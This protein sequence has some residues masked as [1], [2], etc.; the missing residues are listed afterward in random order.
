MDPATSKNQLPSVHRS[1][2]ANLLRRG[3]GIIL[4]LMPPRM[5]FTIIYRRRIWRDSESRSGSGSSLRATAAIR[6]ELPRLL[7][8]LQIKSMLDV[9]C[10][11]LNWMKEVN[12][13]AVNYLGVDIVADLIATNRA[14]FAASNRRFECLD[15]L[16]D[17]I[18]AVDL[19]F[20]RD[21]LVHFSSKHIGTAIGNVKAS[22]SKYFATTTFPTIWEN[23]EIPTGQHRPINLQSP[24]FNFPEPVRL[25]D[26]ST[27]PPASALALIKKVGVWKVSD[28]PSLA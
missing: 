14:R 15:I 27:P 5:V 21:C 7:T 23:E 6:A 1:S 10:G 18:P 17:Q 25:L 19:I 13:G 3:R 22:G 20:C 24:P 16:Q 8:A 11:D 12:L 4:S 28:L 26:D 9:P 2:V